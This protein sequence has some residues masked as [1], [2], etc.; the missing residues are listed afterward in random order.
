MLEQHFYELGTKSDNLTDDLRLPADLHHNLEKIRLEV[1]AHRRP[2]YANYQGRKRI[3]TTPVT[4]GSV[5]APLLWLK[6]FIRG[7]VD[8]AASQRRR[9]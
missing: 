6:P 5:M 2:G 4:G 1:S 7:A 3:E 8:T 9:R